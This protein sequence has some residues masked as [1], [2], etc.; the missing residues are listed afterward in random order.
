MYNYK[1]LKKGLLLILTIIGPLTASAQKQPQVQEVSVRAPDNVKIDGKINEWPNPFLNTHSTDTYL[2]A[3]NSSSRIYYTMANDD[4][5][6]YLT[7]RGLGNGVAKKSLAGGMT[8]T[9]SHA[10][11]K[12]TRAKAAD[13]VAIT[14]PVPQDGK[15]TAGI[16]STINQLFALL[17]D[18]VANRKQ[19][20]SI[21]TIAN[22]RV[23]NAMKEIRVIGVK[24]VPDSVISVYNTAGF[25]A[26]AQFTKVQLVIELAI[27]LKYLGLSVDNPAP[28]SYNIKLS[29]IPDPN[30][31][32][33][34]SFP[35]PV[36]MQDSNISAPMPMVAP[37]LNYEYAS[38][39]TD[40]WGVYTLAK[41][42]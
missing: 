7:I 24:E 38:N 1:K 14:F 4:N 33:S 2:N 19:I 21:V 17:D 5:N 11:E 25:K 10:T 36:V 13:N 22:K 20:D 18:S 15:T 41:K 27:P 12:R 9:I 26:A 16:M 30:Q 6:L 23:N 37:N 39:P 29:A 40:F 31:G 42:Q 8:L 3:Y 34:A 35:P 32:G 28:F